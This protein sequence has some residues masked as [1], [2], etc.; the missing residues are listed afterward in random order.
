MM[1]EKRY[2]MAYG[3]NLSMEQMAVRCPDAKVVGPA[4]LG[5]WRLLFKGCA[6]IEPCEEKNTPVLVWEISER[7][8]RNLDRY[9]GFPSFYYKKELEVEVFPLQGREPEK[10]TAMVYIM[11]EKHSCRAPSPYY[12]RV[13][14]EGYRDFHFPMHVLTQALKDSIGKAEARRFLE[15]GGFHDLRN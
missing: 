1:K 6:T 4:V 12:Y 13:L 9:E 14:E 2:Y 5:G 11:D 10:L 7:D 15:R 8:E 3:S